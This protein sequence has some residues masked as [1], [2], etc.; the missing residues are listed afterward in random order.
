MVSFF[1]ASTKFYGRVAQ[2][3]RRSG[4]FCAPQWRRRT[5]RI[6][7]I[8]SVFAPCCRYLKSWVSK[9]CWLFVGLIR[10]VWFYYYKKPRFSH[11][12]GQWRKHPW[13]VSQG[14]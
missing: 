8:Y 7:G 6:L 10:R 2:S 5:M 1:V 3:R 14:E 13:V 12:T 9:G 11:K 4:Q